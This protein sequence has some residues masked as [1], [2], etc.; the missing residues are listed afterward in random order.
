MVESHVD[1]LTQLAMKAFYILACTGC[2]IY[3]SLRIREA[4][5]RFKLGELYD[6]ME[7]EEKT[8]SEL[9]KLSDSE[10]ADRVS[11]DLARKPKTN[12]GSQEG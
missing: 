5:R 8:R 4:Y 3:I 7:H 10:L 12:N 9:N 2:L 6:L 11:N 1:T